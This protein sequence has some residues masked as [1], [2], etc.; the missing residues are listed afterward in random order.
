MYGSCY[1][2]VKLTLI[3]GSTSCQMVTQSSATDHK[4][5]QSRE[6]YYP[7]VLDEIPRMS[8]GAIYGGQ[9]RVKTER[10]L[11]ELGHSLC[12]GP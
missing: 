2:F 5:N 9:G 10:L 8:R 3:K 4:R 7:K 6:V 12:Q 1:G 11:L